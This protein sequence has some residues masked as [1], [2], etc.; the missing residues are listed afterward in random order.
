M[1]TKVTGSGPG[2]SK[3]KKGQGTSW[4]V[5]PAEEG[6][7]PIAK[8]DPKQGR[9]RTTHHKEGGKAPIAYVVT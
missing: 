7:K 5:V 2:A 4:T 1:E 3:C 9:N 8:K 6:D